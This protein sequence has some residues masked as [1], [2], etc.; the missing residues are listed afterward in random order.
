MTGC[1]D[2]APGGGTVTRPGGPRRRRTSAEVHDLLLAAAREEFAANG[3]VRTGTHAVAAAAGVREPLL[4]RHFGGK[5]NLFDEAV[6][7]PVGAVV[8]TALGD[9]QGAGSGPAE[10]VHALHGAFRHALGDYRREL[11]AIIEVQAHVP[12]LAST[13]DRI[14]GSLGLDAAGPAR[15]ALAVA[16]AT[17]AFGTDTLGR[18]GGARDLAVATPAHDRP[19]VSETHDSICRHATEEFS[20]IGYRRTTMGAIATRA[21]VGESTISR[22]FHDKAELFDESVGRPLERAVRDFESRW[23]GRAV[24]GDGHDFLA[25]LHHFLRDHRRIILVLLTVNAFD[26]PARR[27]VRTAGRSAERVFRAVVEGHPP[28]A[29]SGRAAAAADVL[30]VVLGSAVLDDRPAVTPEM[31]TVAGSF[32]G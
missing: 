13:I 14:V 21:G 15:A 28:V 19:D 4:F 18:D 30:A 2:A 20:R 22:H 25:A 26:A 5:A 24:T 16:V 6:V 12:E 7:A 1:A 9:R 11:V 3:Y 23:S 29:R 27:I 10:D 17:I 32:P 31:L 8:Q